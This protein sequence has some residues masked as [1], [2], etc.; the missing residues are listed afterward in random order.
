M[1]WKFSTAQRIRMGAAL[2]VVFLLVLATNMMDSNHFTIVQ[3]NLTTVY[4]DRILAKDYLF[5]ISR[6]LQTKRTFLQENNIDDL[7]KY[8]SQANDSIETLMTRFAN[9]RHTEKET[10]HFE[11]LFDKLNVLIQYESQYIKGELINEELPSIDIV[12]SYY[13][14]VFEELDAL[15][16]IQLKE[17]SRIIEQSHKA[18]DTSHLISRIEEITLI[19]IGLLIQLIIFIRPIKD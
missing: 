3:D 4:E 8:S 9:T 5:R 18:I 19:V 13:A 11:S 6:Q 14:A 16:E 12:D 7:V 15:F 2:A 10:Q 1:N 17:G